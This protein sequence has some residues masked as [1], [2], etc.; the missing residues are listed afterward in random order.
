MSLKRNDFVLSYRDSLIESSMY[1]NLIQ[2]AKTAVNANDVKEY[3]RIRDG[4]LTET[5]SGVEPNRLVASILKEENLNLS[6]RYELLGVKTSSLEGNN[7]WRSIMH[8]SPVS[9]T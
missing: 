8:T 1:K 7:L 6:F 2:A 9:L 5:K 4:Y 3:V